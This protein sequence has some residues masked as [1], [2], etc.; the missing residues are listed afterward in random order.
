[1]TEK[2]TLKAG[3]RNLKQL[4]YR[5]VFPQ[6]NRKLQEVSS[7]WSPSA[8][9]SKLLHSKP[10]QSQLLHSSVNYRIAKYHSKL[11]EIKLLQ[12]KILRQTIALLIARRPPQHSAS[13]IDC[14]VE[15]GCGQNLRIGRRVLICNYYITNC[16]RKTIAWQTIPEKTWADQ[17]IV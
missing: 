14:C 15:T 12:S 4:F 11:S 1:M 8:L 9:N 6:R 16:C 3:A 7:T 5:D 13:L 17:T 10:S 2:L